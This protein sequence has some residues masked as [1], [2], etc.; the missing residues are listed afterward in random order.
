[1]INR[2]KRHT[3]PFHVV[4]SGGK[5]IVKREGNA[6]P[7]SSWDLKKDAVSDGVNRARTC[8]TLLFVHDA[9]G[10]IQERRDLSGA[11]STPSPNRKESNES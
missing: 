11:A 6:R 10:F 7:S 8:K 3:R 2:S 5:W 9:K 1:M 4:Y